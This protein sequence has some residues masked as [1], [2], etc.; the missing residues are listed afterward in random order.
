[1]SKT[2]KIVRFLKLIERFEDSEVMYSDL[3]HPEFSQI[4]YPNAL[5]KNGQKSNYGEV[6]KRLSLGK[7]MLAKQ[8]YKIESTLEQND[9][10]Y[11][12]S[13]WSGTIAMD[14]GHFKRGQQLRAHLCMAFEFKDN[15]IY[16]QKNYDCFLPF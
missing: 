8:S 11:I 5:N 14:A 4:E 7:A 10:A 6:F 3:L 1:M 12:E 15:R 2:E 16:K 9:R 13:I